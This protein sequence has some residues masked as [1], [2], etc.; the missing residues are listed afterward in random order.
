V[1]A[2]EQ[3]RAAVPSMRAESSRLAGMRA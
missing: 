3:R 1:H 2:R